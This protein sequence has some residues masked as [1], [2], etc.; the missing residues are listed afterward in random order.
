MVMKMARRP[1]KKKLKRKT[2]T[3]MMTTSTH[4]LARIPRSMRSKDFVTPVS[5]YM[6][7]RKASSF[8]LAICRIRR[9]VWKASSAQSIKN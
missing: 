7:R 3:M 2:M 4:N 9:S 5:T 8:T 1:R 6:T